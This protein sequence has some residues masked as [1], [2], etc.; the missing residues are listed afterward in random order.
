ME[1]D[2]TTA[3]GHPDPDCGCLDCMSVDARLNP[4]NGSAASMG[5]FHSDKTTSSNML[6]AVQVYRGRRNSCAE[7]SD[8]R[9]IRK[10]AGLYG[11]SR[12]GVLHG[13]R[14]AEYVRPAH[15]KASWL[16]GQGA[17]DVIGGRRPG[18]VA[19]FQPEGPRFWFTGR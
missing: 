4:G 2:A 18:H 19:L 1:W 16:E 6:F 11:V 10:C 12:P 7:P 9:W 3:R 13:E 5:Q 17:D 15:Y 8:E 14:A